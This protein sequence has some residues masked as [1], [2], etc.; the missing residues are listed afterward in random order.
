M[1]NNTLTLCTT[2]KETPKHQKYKAQPMF[3]QSALVCFLLW[4]SSIENQ[5]SI[6][7]ARIKNTASKREKQR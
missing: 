3:M 5:F 4:N 6:A 2:K 1:R 7:K